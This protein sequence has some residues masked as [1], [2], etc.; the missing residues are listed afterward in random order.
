M[1]LLPPITV[2]H[3]LTE[4]KGVVPQMKVL[5]W[6]DRQQFGLKE[7]GMN[8]N[9]KLFLLLLNDNFILLNTK[10]N[11]KQFMK[12]IHFKEADIST[13]NRGIRN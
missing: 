10:L 11:D 6:S 8:R 9:T 3:A 1:K 5:G 7:R 4:H 2:T 13:S 12:G